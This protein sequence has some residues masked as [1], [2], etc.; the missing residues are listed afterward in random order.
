MHPSPPANHR[1][2]V[3]DLRNTPVVCYCRYTP[4]GVVFPCVRSSIADQ[5]GQAKSRVLMNLFLTVYRLLRQCSHPPGKNGP[6][7]RL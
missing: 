7:T 3:F 2:M 1:W 6:G 4:E 5:A